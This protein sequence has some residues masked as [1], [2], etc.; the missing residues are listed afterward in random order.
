MKF[1]E[2]HFSRD[3]RYWLGI[4]LESGG[5]YLGI[6][7]SNSMVDYIEY[8]WIDAEQYRLLSIDPA[9]AFEFA[10]ACRRRENDELLVYTPG[11]DRG[12]PR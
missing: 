12:V 5:N 2:T 8:Y 9:R 6:P 10:E 4:E 11:N 1:V 7:I 3:G